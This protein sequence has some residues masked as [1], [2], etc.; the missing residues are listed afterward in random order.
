MRRVDRILLLLLG[1][2]WVLVVVVAALSVDRPVVALPYYLELGG[3]PPEIVALPRWARPP[4]ESADIRVGDRLI[5]VDGKPVAGAGLL[6]IAALSWAAMNED[7]VVPVEL[8]RD[9]ARFSGRA[10]LRGVAPR[11]PAFLV[12]LGC[13][14]FAIG[15]I[16]RLPRLRIAQVGFP[17]FMVTALWLGGQFGRTPAEELVAFCVRMAGVTLILPLAVRA[18]RWFP[19]GVEYRAA[20]ARGWPWLLALQGVLTVNTELGLGL[21]PAL[22]DLAPKLLSGF[23]LA[24]VLT[25]ATQNFRAASPAGRRRFKWL[26]LGLYAA[27]LPPTTVSVISAFDPDFGTWFIPSHLADLALPAALLIGIWK[28]NLFDIDRVLNAALVYLTLAG[29]GL[30]LLVVWVPAA[31]ESLALSTGVGADTSRAVL[32]GGVLL[33]LLPPGV[34]LRGWL[35]RLVLREQLAR[36]SEIALLSAQLAS[37]D[38]VQ[39]IAALLAERVPAMWRCAGA[40]MYA[41]TVDGLAPVHA[42]GRAAV[43]PDDEFPLEKL[44]LGVPWEDSEARLWV[45]LTTGARADLRVLGAIMLGSRSE[46]DDWAPADRAQLASVAERGVARLVSLESS[47]RLREAR[48]LTESLTHERDAAVHATREKT[49]FLATASHDLRQPLHALGLFLGALEARI[50]DPEARTLLSNVRASAGSMGQLFDAL[51]DVT[52]LDAGVLAPQVEEGVAIGPLLEGL[53]RELEPLAGV[54]GIRLR[55]APSTLAVESDPRLLRSIVQN[56]VGNALRYTNRG[57][58]LIGAR[59]RGDRVRIEVWDT[60]PGLAAD[61]VE[62]LFQ[63]WRR[64]DASGAASRGNPDGGVGLGLSIVQRLSTLL[65]YPLDVASRPGFGSMFAVEVPR[66]RTAQ[67]SSSESPTSVDRLPPVRVLVIDDDPGTL[68]GLRALLE[69]W[70]LEVAAAADSDAALR[71]LGDGAPAA[72]LA[73]LRLRGGRSGVDAIAAVRAALGRAVPACLVTAEARDAAL[74]AGREA[75]LPVLF[76]P[77][78]PVRLRAALRHLLRSSA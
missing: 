47:V 51:L 20:W 8:E 7:G 23:F 53:G 30:G 43:P 11:W 10:A 67:R 66:S 60:G 18:L 38:K 46:G 32:G 71:S 41:E 31:A 24:L 65:G 61:E 16:L 54:R 26:L 73:D 3:G 76:K 12:S 22:R 39:E 74:A 72:I 62:V 27:L 52:R 48:A 63:A 78:E 50:V 19:D 35:D 6:R 40:V 29:I 44:R 57:G 68:R 59:R 4:V 1:S 56:L 33:A 75:G 13:G 14:A 28:Q 70:G 9:G 36:E 2:L 64:G 21:P 49:A 17:S 37:A 69:S 5:A 45:P 25:I 15:S 58:V 77:V 55:V 42:S 34:V